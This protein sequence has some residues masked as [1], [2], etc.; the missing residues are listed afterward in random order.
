MKTRNAARKAA[1]RRVGRE[2]STVS[3]RIIEGLEQAVA[4]MRGEND[5]VRVMLVRAPKVN[6]ASCYVLV[7]K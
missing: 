7:T 2:R 6:A 3:E 1:K 5:R 4:W